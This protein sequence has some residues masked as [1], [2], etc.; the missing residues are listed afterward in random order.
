M[1]AKQFNQT[2]QLEILWMP[3]DGSLA[4]VLG[5]GLFGILVSRAL[6]THAQ[7]WVLTAAE[8]AN[9]GVLVSG[10]VIDLRQADVR[11]K[12][13]VFIV[14]RFD[15]QGDCWIGEQWTHQQT[16]DDV[17]IGEDIV[18]RMLPKNPRVCA[19]LLTTPRKTTRKLQRL[20]VAAPHRLA[21]ALRPT[22]FSQTAGTSPLAR[23]S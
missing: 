2:K 11:S 18:V 5:I 4:V 13:G 15:Y 22:P 23:H 16:N 12:D 10:A 17:Q 9:D 19:L 6:I 14:F 20:K 21:K 8:L 3:T 7:Q 1:L